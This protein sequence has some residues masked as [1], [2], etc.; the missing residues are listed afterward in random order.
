MNDWE[1]RV[2]SRGSGRRPRQYEQASANRVHK[3]GI[4]LSKDGGPPVVYEIMEGT[5]DSIFAQIHPKCIVMLDEH[6]RPIGDQGPTQASD[7]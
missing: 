4:R 2:R 7:E 5:H 6:D 3:L 1:K